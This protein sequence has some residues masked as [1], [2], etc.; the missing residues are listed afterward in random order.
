MYAAETILCIG[1][2]AV[3]RGGQLVRIALTLTAVALGALV[4]ILVARPALGR[5][6]RQATEDISRSLFWRDTPTAL[7]AL[8]MLGVLWTA[9]PVLLVRACAP[10]A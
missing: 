5:S 9:F 10:P 3:S 1:V 4:T 6:A 7:A 8:A 2:G